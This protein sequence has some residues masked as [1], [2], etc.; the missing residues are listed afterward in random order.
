MLIT[1][2]Q[3]VTSYQFDNYTQF[4]DSFSK[5]NS[6]L[7]LKSIIISVMAI[8]TI[9]ELDHIKIK[10]EIVISIRKPVTGLTDETVV[11]VLKARLAETEADV[12]SEDIQSSRNRIRHTLELSIDD[13]ELQDLIEQFRP[14]MMAEIEKIRSINIARELYELICSVE[15]PRYRITDHQITLIYSELDSWEQDS[16]TMSYHKHI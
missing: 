12:Y 6:Y 11:D 7:T 8:N 4:A 14:A 9:K 2:G 10:N 3:N 13:P 5:L 16:V 1:E 15:Q